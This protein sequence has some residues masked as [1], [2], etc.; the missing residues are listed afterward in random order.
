MIPILREILATQRDS[1]VAP[2]YAWAFISGVASGDELM[3]TKTLIH[4]EAREGGV[5]PYEGCSGN[6]AP[7]RVGS[8]FSAISHNKRRN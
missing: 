7:V 4:S 1:V 6:S 5:R 3:I 2:A 8:F